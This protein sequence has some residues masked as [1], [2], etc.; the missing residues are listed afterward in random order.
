MTQSRDRGEP[1]VRPNLKLKVLIE[2]MRMVLEI[3]YDERFVT[4]SYR[5][6][7]GMGRHTAMRICA[8]KMNQNDPKLDLNELVS[9][10]NVFYKPE[11]IYAVNL[12]LKVDRVKT[13]VHSAVS[14]KINFLGLELQAV[15]PSVLHPPM[16]EKAIRAKEKYLR[17]KGVRALGLRNAWEGNRRKFDII[18]ALSNKAEDN[19]E[20]PYMKMEFRFVLFLAALILFLAYFEGSAALNRSSFPD[21]FIFG[22]GSSAYQYEGATRADGRQPSIWDTFTKLYPEKITDRSN[23]DVADEFYYLLKE[24]VARM[25]EVG[26]DFFRF[27]ISWPRILP[28]GKI[29]GGINQKG[30]NFYNHLIDLLLSNGIQP[31]VTL[32]HWDLPQ[33]LEDEYGGFLSPKIVDDFRDYANLC[34]QEFGDRVK[35]WATLNEPNLFSKEG[36]ATGD[37]APGRCSIY[38]GNCSEGN[39]ATEPYIVM[40]HFILSHA[41]AVQLYKE[42]Y[43]ALQYGTI[44]V[45]VNCNWYVPKFDTIASKRAAQRARDF[46][47]GWAIH[48]VVYGDY[49]KIM[50]EMVGNRLPNFT[51]EQSEMIKGSFNILG[52]NY[53]TTMYAEDSGYDTGAN[54]SYTT[55]SRVNT[56]TEK[57]GIPIC[58]STSIS[59][60]P[61][62]PW[63]LRDI[64]LYIKGRYKSPTI[65]VTENGIG[66]LVN[67]SVHLSYLSKTI[68]EG[69]D[70]RGYFIWSFLDNFEW[71]N[72]YTIRS[73]IT[74]VDYVN[75]LQRYFKNSALWF[76]NFLKKENIASATNS[77][78]LYFE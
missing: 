7:L 52:V 25:K 30:I 68:K 28:L 21:G 65:I 8:F 16:S 53:Y 26:L 2:A 71:A 63:G 39:S 1:L 32:F 49:P 35:Q 61:I 3:V 27:S 42:K 11:K 4:F 37:S 55:D 57:N 19:G 17:Q 58:E 59:F 29:S 50:R 54:L 10:S 34:F 6:C 18:S 31:F 43:Q 23:G 48:P 41:T 24:D 51:K 13:A 20:T 40:H 22:A 36:Y 74:Y 62:C 56:S 78:L 5:G 14:E 44:G 60:L 9:A 45:T 38:I 77:S 47:W 76:H 46:D 70:V 15:S 67:S 72:G 64:L 69:V 33:A 75:G 12:D 66:Y 73:G